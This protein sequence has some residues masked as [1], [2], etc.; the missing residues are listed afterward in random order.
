MRELLKSDR[1]RLGTGAESVWHSAGLNLVLAAFYFAAAKLGLSLA[2][3]HPSA[4]AVWPPAGIALAA[5]LLFGNRV[6]P[7]IALGAF[8]ANATTAGSL[9][10]SAGI[11]AG[12][13]LEGL[14]GAWLAN[15]FA[16]G[17][18]ALSRPR[19]ILKFIGLAAGLST[20]VSATVGA[21]TL[22]IAGFAHWSD[23]GAIWTT[24]DR[25]PRDRPAPPAL[26]SGSASSS[27]PPARRGDLRRSPPHRD[28]GRF[29]RRHRSEERADRVVL[30]PGRGLGGVPLWPACR[31]HGGGRALGG[32]R[33][34]HR[35]WPGAFRPGVGQC[36]PSPSPIVPGRRRGLV[37]HAV[38][39]RRRPRAH[40]GGPPASAR[41]AGG[42]GP[43]SDGGPV[44][45]QSVAAG[46]DGGT[47]AA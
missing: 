10:T 4:S 30:D 1:A 44:P 35:A 19:D 12:N 32:H 40:H 39:G 15:R 3:V 7:G 25:R 11:A 34:G 43:R 23:Y 28:R 46:R 18:E 31:R 24:W 17:K 33:V 14:V 2:I 36:L 26:D 22:S 29:L 8:L 9:A 27:A 41:R 37:A 21:T 6:W 47:L 13:T 38:R 42:A 45:G 20:I 5:F 16:G